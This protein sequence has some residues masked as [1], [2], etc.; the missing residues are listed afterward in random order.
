MPPR[1]P[2]APAS[3]LRPQLASRPRSSAD[4]RRARDGGSDEDLVAAT[5]EDDPMR[6]FLLVEVEPL[7]VVAAHAFALDD[8]RSANR[9]PLARLLANLARLALGPALDA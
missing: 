4:V 6:A 7:A 5:S 9:P 2:Q 3:T 1:T 8:L